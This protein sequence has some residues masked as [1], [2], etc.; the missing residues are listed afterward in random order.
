[1]SEPK[2]TKAKRNTTIQ[3][4]K[5]NKRRQA[6]GRTLESREKQLVKLS[7]DEAERIIKSGKATSQL[8]THF[9][10]LGSVTEQLAREKLKHENLLLQAKAE[11][12][13]S[14]ARMEELYAGAIAVMREYAGKS[15]IKNPDEDE[16]YDD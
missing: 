1:M 9:L 16:D 12:I 7:M 3:A 11:A 15:S 5:T 8:L 14:E 2:G 13:A 10:K 6:P 4:K